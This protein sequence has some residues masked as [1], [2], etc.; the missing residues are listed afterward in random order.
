MTNREDILNILD[1]I[2]YP[3]TG[4][5]ITESGF[6]AEVAIGERHMG[7]V[8]KFRRAHEPFAASLRRQAADALSKAFP[9]SE[10][11]VEIEKAES[12]EKAG[13]T[14]RPEAAANTRHLPEVGKVIAVASGKGGVGKSS[15]AAY[16]ALALSSEGYN[17]GILDADI[18]GPSQPQLFGVSDY[19]PVSEGDG[20]LIVPAESMGVKVMS[21]GFFISQSDALVWRGPM[22][23]NALRQLIHQTKW[24]TLDY[25]LIDLPPGTGDVHLTI[26]HELEMDGAIIVSTPQSLAV[27]DVRRGV[28]MFR[29]KGIEIPVLGVV[30]NM[31][32]FT[33][34]ELPDNRYYIFGYDGARQFA[35]AEGLDFLGDI[36]IVQSVMD[37]G[38]SGLPS[39][40]HLS[41][42]LPYY[43]NIAKKV[44]DKLRK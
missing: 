17:V 3:E 18:Y 25:L 8:L 24:G 44:V 39:Q 36:P 13:K 26:A 29:S 37:S 10:I 7:V 4:N 9:E 41:T 15:V 33:P 35:E 6:V 11:S 22:A 42:V 16:L 12:T 21:I 20:E 32:W 30:E 2:V 14:G 40:K 27:A 31:A 19:V 43:V 34:A 1:G 38:E 28:E 5:S 23:A